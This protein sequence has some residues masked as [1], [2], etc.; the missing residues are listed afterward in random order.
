M[1]P[2]KIAERIMVR[3]VDVAVRSVLQQEIEQALREAEQ[4]GREETVRQAVGEWR[5]GAKVP[6]HVY[7]NDKPMFT[8]PSE[9]IARSIV[10]AM[11]SREHLATIVR[12]SFNEVL[13]DIAT[14]GLGWPDTWEQESRPLLSEAVRDLRE[15]NAELVKVLEDCKNVL[16]Q[17][18]STLIG[19][20]GVD[21]CGVARTKLRKHGKDE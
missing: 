4:R 8:A 9:E 16:A 20:A 5:V 21:A 10:Q 14:K 18:P 13:D 2:E 12:K 17:L 6:Q 15:A 19:D 11:N 7:L 3:F 1:T